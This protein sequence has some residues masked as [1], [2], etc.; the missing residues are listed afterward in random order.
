MF[1]EKQT[2][3]KRAHEISPFKGGK[4]YLEFSEDLSKVERVEVDLANARDCLSFC[5]HALGGMWFKKISPRHIIVAYSNGLIH[6][7]V[8]DRFDPMDN[9]LIHRQ[10]RHAVRN[11]MRNFIEEVNTNLPIW[12]KWYQQEAELSNLIE[13]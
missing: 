9:V 4:V 11:I 12:K 5:E 13:W 7:Y 2:L 3:S 10:F 8:D 6:D 1:T